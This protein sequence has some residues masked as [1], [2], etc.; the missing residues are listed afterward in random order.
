MLSVMTEPV[1]HEHTHVRLLAGHASTGRPVHEQVPAALVEQAIYDVLASP[2]IA[3]GFAAGDRVRV[4]E[5][6]SFTVLQRGGNL[7]V[8]LLPA[9]PPSDADAQPRAGQRA[10]G[11]APVGGQLAARHACSALRRWGQPGST[12]PPAACCCRWSCTSS[13]A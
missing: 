1:K 10:A 3:Y 13:S 4:G 7:C 5:D 2:A 8:V 11:A 9:N 6:G 12:W